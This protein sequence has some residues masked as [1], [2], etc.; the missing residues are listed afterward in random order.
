MDAE[1]HANVSG[2]R[3]PRS[4]APDEIAEVIHEAIRV[5]QRRVGEDVSP[6]WPEAPDWM[7]ESTLK[8]IIGVFAGKS[9]RES[10]EAWM[11][12]RESAGW[13][14]GPVK[15]IADRVSPNLI[16]YDELPV[17]QQV[18]DHLFAAIVRSFTEVGAGP[19]VQTLREL[20]TELGLEL[21]GEAPPA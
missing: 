4:F 7:K 1:I 21:P 19:K 10:H 18:K 9:A 2:S 15:S 5:V 17:E 11:A 14:Y 3:G 8:G 12:E 20:A 13:T 16:P 6:P